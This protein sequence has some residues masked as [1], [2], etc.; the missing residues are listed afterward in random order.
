MRKGRLRQMRRIG[1][2]SRKCTPCVG[3]AATRRDAVLDP[4]VL[5]SSFIGRPDAAPGRVI[6]AWREGRFTLVVSP[7]LLAELADV[8][9]RP[10]LARWAGEDW[11]AAF[12][13]ALAAR[14]EHHEDPVHEEPAGLRDPDDEY[15]VALARRSAVDFLVS[16]DLDLLE[17]PLPDLTVIAPAEFLSALDD[18]PQTRT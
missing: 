3:A 17:A 11:G 1:W 12:V 8:L 9:R 4:S 6:Q 10:K 13:A 18:E 14:S 5:I 16:L 15:L 2:R 7:A